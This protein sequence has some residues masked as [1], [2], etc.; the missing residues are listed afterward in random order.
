MTD[1]EIKTFFILKYGRPDL[2]NT[3]WTFGLPDEILDIIVPDAETPTFG[4]NVRNAKAMSVF[5]K[6]NSLSIIHD[7]EI[8]FEE[9]IFRRYITHM[10]KQ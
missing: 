8:R 1:E 5:I 4:S 3:E 9:Y 10:R 6:F 7:A 2:Y